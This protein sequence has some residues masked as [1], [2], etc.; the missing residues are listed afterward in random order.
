MIHR[1]LVIDAFGDADYDVN[2]Y[3]FQGTKDPF[4][5]HRLM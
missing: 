4:S 5:A 1:F 3:E 2:Q